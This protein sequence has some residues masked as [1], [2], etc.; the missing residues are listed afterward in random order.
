L[1]SGLLWFGPLLVCTLP[2]LAHNVSSSNADFLAGVDGPAVGLFVYLG[3]KH[4]VTGVDHLLYLFGVVFL[5]SAP[6]SVLLFV[7]LF[8]IGH[9]ITLVCGVLFGWQVN[10]RLVDAVIGLSVAYKAFENLA[11]FDVLFG[12]TPDIRLMVFGFGLIHGLG[13]ATK[14]QAVYSGGDG[15]L[16][17]LLAFNVGV[18]IGQLLALAGLLLGLAWLRR[19]PGFPRWSQTANTLLMA[20]GFAFFFYHVADMYLGAELVR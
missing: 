8:A 19:A 20:C 10:P 18:E 5:L 11:G 9:S 2:L 16:V 6:R 1:W 12:R 4:M 3:A 14:L 17:N 7:T 13:L 15:L